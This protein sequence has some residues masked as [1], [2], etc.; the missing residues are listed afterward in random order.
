[1]PDEDHLD[2]EVLV[3]VDLTESGIK[4]KAKSR[5]LSAVDRW[6]GNVFEWMNVRIE[7]DTSRRRAEIDARKRVTAAAAN[8]Y[9]RELRGSPALAE[10]MVERIIRKDMREQ[11]NLNAI[12]S[13]ALDDL[14][15]NP[16]N[17]DQSATGPDQLSQEF[18]DRLE[19]YGRR[20]TSEELRERWARILAA[21]VRVP[22][23]FGG[24]VLRIVDELDTET[25]RLFERLC[26]HNLA[27]ALPKSLIGELPFEDQNRLT[28]AELLHSEPERGAIIFQPQT[29]SEGS[30]WWTAFGEYGIAI[31]RSDES[32]F[33][34]RVERIV[35]PYRGNPSLPVYF[36]TPPGAA[37]ASILP[38]N[39]RA[40]AT[41]LV[42]VL[43]NALPS[44]H[45]VL[46]RRAPSD[47]A[48]FEPIVP[49]LPSEK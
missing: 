27:D 47:A 9:A 18:L 10:R 3:S 35:T 29:F 37:V 32:P 20:A 15:E 28:A 1:M 26:E 38:K 14:R 2:R 22:D 25:A 4:A 41:R 43:A 31:H 36:L 19:G 7:E 23:T 17:N 33:A 24:R 45:I 40:A 8:A 42:R 30:I 46:Y 39:E 11:A 48:A 34:T 6:G 16:P 21:E 5:F 13:L 44:R 12:S 49:D